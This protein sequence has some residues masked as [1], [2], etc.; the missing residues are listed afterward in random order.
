MP[1]IEKIVAVV[2]VSYVAAVCLYQTGY[3]N[4]RN[5]VITHP[6]RSE[7][8]VMGWGWDE[9]EKPLSPDGS[10]GFCWPHLDGNG[11]HC[12]IRQ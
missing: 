12:G 3:A 7:Y 1:P 10:G 11:S 4:G 2:V 8:S 5:D 6:T 9:T